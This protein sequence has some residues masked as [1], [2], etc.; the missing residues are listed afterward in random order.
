MNKV[1]FILGQTDYPPPEGGKGIIQL[2][3][4][5][6]DLERRDQP[7]NKNAE[8]VSVTVYPSRLEGLEWEVER[9]H[10]IGGS[11]DALVP[12]PQTAGL[13][14]IGG[15]VGGIFKKSVSNFWQ[16]EALD[17]LIIDP[18]DDYIETRIKEDKLVKAYIEKNTRFNSWSI[19]MITGLAI[20]RGAS[21]TREEKVGGDVHGGLKG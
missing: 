18:P 21:G 16:F 7:I 10:Y 14:S 3:H 8:P 13:V 20:A 1:W 15:E 19:F 17:K 11:A 2:G 5:V 6:P 9:D 4:F 12:I